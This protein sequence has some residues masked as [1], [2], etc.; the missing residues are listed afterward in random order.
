[1][2]TENPTGRR[3]TVILAGG[4]FWGMEELLREIPGVLETEVGYSGGFLDNATYPDVKRGT[5]GHAEAVRVVFDPERLPFERLLAWFFRMH[6]P[7][8]K[9]RQGN[10][11]GSQY[12]SAIFTTTEEQRHTAAEVVARVEASGKWK[13]PLTTEVVPAGAFWRAEDYHQGYLQQYPNGYTCHYLRD[14]DF[15][16]EVEA[17]AVGAQRPLES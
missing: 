10:D 5:T 3:E 13:R 16:A 15:E 11:V 6:D 12:R 17:E 1:M 2:S 8:T 7:T 4:C 14:F 9:N